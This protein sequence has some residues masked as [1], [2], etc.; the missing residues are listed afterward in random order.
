M[1][2]A[3]EESQ[4]SQNLQ[5]L[6]PLLRT[7]LVIKTEH[8]EEEKGIQYVLHWLQEHHMRY[9]VVVLIN[10]YTSIGFNS[11]K[12]LTNAIAPSFQFELLTDEW[13]SRAIWQTKTIEQEYNKRQ[14]QGLAYSSFLLSLLPECLIESMNLDFIPAHLMQSMNSKL[15]VIID[16]D[17]T[18]KLAKQLETLQTEANVNWICLTLS[19]TKQLDK[20]AE[21]II[22]VTE[23]TPVEE[24]K[25]TIGT[26]EQNELPKVGLH[27][28]RFHD[29]YGK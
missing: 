1:S 18:E 12:L 23:N 14:T 17:P 4:Q 7:R 11:L 15:I 25:E 2:Q 21:E 22:T 20:I 6:Q 9:A 29:F 19:K 26:I 24:F 8:E 5:L 13:I 10:S 27:G 3:S 16:Y 28:W